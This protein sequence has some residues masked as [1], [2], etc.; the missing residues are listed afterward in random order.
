MYNGPTFRLMLP[1]RFMG[2]PEE[3]SSAIAAISLTAFCGLI[4]F[5][6]IFRFIENIPNSDDFDLFLGFVNSFLSTDDIGD[7]FL[8]LFSPHNEHIV[9]TSRLAALLS[10]YLLGTVS[11]LALLVFSHMLILAS[12][13]ILLKS[14]KAN[15]GFLALLFSLLVFQPQ[16]GEV[17]VWASA[18]VSF[19]S[20]LFWA[21]LALSCAQSR[22]PSIGIALICCMLAALCNAAGLAVAPAIATTQILQRRWRTACFWLATSVA[23]TLALSSQA[24]IVVPE[25]LMAFG[26]SLLGAS[27]SFE[28][29]SASFA[30][31]LLL[32]FLAVGILFS[33]QLRTNVQLRGM[34]IFS[35]ISIAVIA[36]GRHSAALEVAYLTSRY[37]LF[38]VLVLAIVALSLVQILLNKLPSRRRTILVSSL[39]L[40]CCFALLSFKTFSY[41]VSF[42]SPLLRDSAIRWQLSAGG[43]MHP[44]AAYAKAILQRSV[45]LKLYQPPEMELAPYLA[46]AANPSKHAK[47]GKMLAA[48]EHFFNENGYLFLSGWAFIPGKDSKFRSRWLR[49]WSPQQSYSYLLDHR[50]RPDVTRHFMWKSHGRNLNRSGFAVLVDCSEVQAGDYVVQIGIEAAGTAIYRPLTRLPNFRCSSK[51]ESLG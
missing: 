12:L 6:W 41:E 48:A 24:K 22:W 14:T 23:L 19:S 21:V 33:P 8:L 20:M 47:G 37:R 1:F 51:Q 30:G 25:K 49:I 5:V 18:A 40:A 46:K 45:E 11:L 3:Q 35:L 44:N 9:L 42:R 27:L 16:Y 43:L 34:L 28:N 17:L 26:V 4:F 36:W 38:S 50:P 31:G 7:R 15:S 10:F 2:Q 39:I 13:L 29:A 32:G